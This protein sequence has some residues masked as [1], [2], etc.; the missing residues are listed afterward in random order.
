MIA[1]EAFARY[2]YQHCNRKFSLSN[3]K[4]LY[5]PA[6]P[7][8]GNQPEER[9]KEYE[10]QDDSCDQWREQIPT[11]S[12]QFAVGI[13]HVARSPADETEPH[14]WRDIETIPYHDNGP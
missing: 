14:S 11:Y 4:S 1:H 9:K 13:P 10:C 8:F 6:A 5:S 12:R 3:S 7:A 2:E